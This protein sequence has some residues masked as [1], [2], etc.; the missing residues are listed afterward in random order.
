LRNQA[1]GDLIKKLP[2][3]RTEIA[4]MERRGCAKVATASDPIT[5]N[6][7][8]THSQVNTW[9][10][11]LFPRLF[12]YAHEHHGDHCKN[13]SRNSSQIWILLS[14]ERRSL[15]TVPATEPTGSDL[16]RFKGRDHA[17]TADSHVYIGT[18]LSAI[19]YNDIYAFFKHW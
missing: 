13:S 18:F 16:M 11:N 2:P 17:P 7:T 12:E 4:V 6:S 14:K 9:L 1:E 15:Q 3:T 8:W 19:C 10:E 5:I